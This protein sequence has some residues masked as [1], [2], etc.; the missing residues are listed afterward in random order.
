MNRNNT[1]F[2][3]NKL[4]VYYKLKNFF[5]DNYKRRGTSQEI[6]NEISARYLLDAIRLLSESGKGYSW[7]NSVFKAENVASLTSKSFISQSDKKMIA[8]MQVNFLAYYLKKR[9]YGVFYYSALDAKHFLRKK[10]LIR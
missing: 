5:F 6:S 7:I 3:E 2:A 1:L 8:E 9:V 10:G 4:A